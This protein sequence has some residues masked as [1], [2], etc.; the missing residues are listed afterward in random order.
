MAL[1]AEQKKEILTEYG[2]HDTDTGS[3][4]WRHSTCRSSTGEGN[5]PSGTGETSVSSD[6]RRECASPAMA[7]GEGSG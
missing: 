7:A 3:P 5:S 2:L 1:T 6:G 4:R